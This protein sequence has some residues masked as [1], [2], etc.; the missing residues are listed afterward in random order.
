MSQKL[1]YSSLHLFTVAD[2]KDT[3]E[4][5]L[6]EQGNFD[7]LT[8]IE[9]PKGKAVLDHCH[10]TQYVRGVLHRQSNV[11]LGKIENGFVRYV[12]Y[13][14]NGSLSDFLRRAADYL[15][16]GV[17]ERYIHPGWIAKSKTEF[18]KL[19]EKNKDALLQ[20]MNLPTGKNSTERK[21]I[22]K[23]ALLSR[24]I[25]FDD[26]LRALD[27]TIETSIERL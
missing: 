13:W 7:A 6:I 15:D 11:M 22:F 25:T 24:R 19:S 18:N 12:K 9:I 1:D 3:R 10:D 21:E 27:K 5:L 26:V 8:G 14:Y 17:D 23:D 4:K 16:A 2:V 20:F